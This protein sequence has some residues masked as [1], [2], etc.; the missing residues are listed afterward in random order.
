MARLKSRTLFPPNG[1]QMTFP[2]AGQKGNFIGSFSEVVTQTMNFLRKNPALVAKHGWPTEIHAVEAW[3]DEENAR[4]MLAHGWVSFVQEAPVEKKTSAQSANRQSLFRSALNVAAAV[5][6]AAI[7]YKDLFSNGPV[8]AEFAEKRAATCVNCP[9]NDT[10]HS[11]ADHFK[12]AMAAEVMSLIQMTRDMN[13]STSLDDQLGVCT[14]C[15]C[16]LKAKVH[17]RIEKVIAGVKPEIVEAL[18]DYCWIKK[19][20]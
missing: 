6:S 16:P 11:I 15:G 4:R 14:S 20:E 2:Q 3:V 13:M 7:A 18:P 1:F 8:P 9:L 12:E 5:K 19:K 10:E 17:V